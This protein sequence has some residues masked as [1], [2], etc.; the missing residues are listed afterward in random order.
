V[1]KSQR[2]L[3]E[4]LHRY[5]TNGE[6]FF[7][8]KELAESCGLSLGTVNPLIKKLERMRIVECRPLGLRLLDPERALVYWAAERDFFKDVTY[9]TFTPDN[10]S[11]VESVVKSIG[12][13]TAHSG[14][15]LIFGK[16]PFEY[17][18]VFVYAPADEI[19]KRYGPREGSPNLFVLHPDDHL[20]KLSQEGTVPLVQ[21]YVD[22]WQMGELRGALLEEIK[23]RLA[24]A[25]LRAIEKIM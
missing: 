15:K 24:G 13:L 25:P 18:C 1:R 6:R 4:M 2:I 11:E 21:L 16:V 3:R 20:K 10:V 9:S 19:K 23:K 7:S 8:Q 5:Y 14:Y 12:L 17:S 22:L